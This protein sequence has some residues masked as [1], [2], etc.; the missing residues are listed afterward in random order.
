MERTL[1]QGM[2]MG[3]VSRSEHKYLPP[4]GLYAGVLLFIWITVAAFAIFQYS[5][6]K[7]YKAELL[8]SNLQR[9]NDRV[10][11]T[12][13]PFHNRPEKITAVSGYY[14][15]LCNKY[16]DIRITIIN[17][18]G[19]VLY[20]SYEKNSV[21][22]MVNHSSRKE[23]QD[24]MRFGSGYTIRR[25]SESTA[26][27]YFYSATKRGKI[28]IR[29]AL[30]YSLSL[31][32]K[33]GSG[34]SF[35]FF[36][37]IVTA[38]LS[39]TFIYM[40]SRFRNNALF[41]ERE[42]EKALHEREE[43]VRIKKQL[44]NNINHELKTPVSGISLCLETILRHPDIS[45]EKRDEFI[46]K[47]YKESLRLNSLLQDISIITRLD[48]ASQI[49]TK[50]ELSLSDLIN[51]EIESF[52][53]DKELLPIRFHIENMEG[54][55]LIINGNDQLLRSIFRNMLN[56]AV[57]YSGCRD[58][59]ICLVKESPDNYLFTFSDNGIGVEPE[60]LQHLFERFYRVDKGRSRKLGGTG[61]GLAIVK[62]AVMLHSGS[63]SVA[64]QDSGGL[65]F[66]FTLAKQ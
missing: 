45:I 47:A 29:S 39:V 38:L 63:I 58:I 42:H 1:S 36:M 19:T 20:D 44:T 33:L 55:E 66:T 12:I 4:S 61:L 28:I 3:T 17:L 51:E 26:K 22:G 7:I 18:T 62:N 32:E 41:I 40:F 8:N 57:A 14:K 56:N 64:N 53:S 48:E 49:I 24:A 13:L 37:L 31:S 16:P 65:I 54:K 30:P 5:R 34:N 27:E 59:T 23:I 9:V 52:R 46:Q 6:E 11:E 2:V 25:H 43:K 10:F 60:H 35:L 15:I 50:E 21:A